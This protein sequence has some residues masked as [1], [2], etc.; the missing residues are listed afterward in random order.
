MVV[1]VAYKYTEIKQMSLGIKNVQ[2]EKLI[3]HVLVFHNLNVVEDLKDLVILQIIHQPEPMLLISTWNLSCRST[4][5]WV[6]HI[7]LKKGF[8]IPSFFIIKE[9][10][11]ERF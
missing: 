7:Y 9:A 10:N 8:I 4:L 5:G 1:V 2:K 11:N 6:D 3:L